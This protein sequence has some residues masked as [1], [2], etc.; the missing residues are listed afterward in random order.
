MLTAEQLEALRRIDTCTV[1]NAIETFEV[2]LRNEG[3]MNASVRCWLPRRDAMLGYAVTAKVRCSN[4]PIEGYAYVDRTD[5]WNHLLK[6]PGPRIVVAQDVDSNPGLGSMWGEVHANLLM[7]LGCLGLVTN[8][9]V[10]DLP[11]IE[12]TG[13]QI[14][15]GSLAVSHAYAH[16]VEV[17]CPVEVGGLKVKPGDLLHGDLHGVVSIPAGIAGA[18][19][20]EAARILAHEQRLIALCRSKETS[21]DQLREAAKDW[22]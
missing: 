13:F 17:G 14:F 3:F 16:I 2:R 10:R 11:G 15:A 9:A 21:L 4:P 5:W 22:K 19:P 20:A 18:I 1:A 6:L 8:G 12:P 7:A